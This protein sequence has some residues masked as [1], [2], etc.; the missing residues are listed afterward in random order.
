MFGQ[1]CPTLISGIL[2]EMRACMSVCCMC[3][4]HWLFYALGYFIPV[5]TR[6]VSSSVSNFLL[7]IWGA[8]CRLEQH[9]KMIIQENG[10]CWQR[11]CGWV[12]PCSVAVMKCTHCIAS[13]VGGKPFESSLATNAL[14][15]C[16]HPCR[17][18]ECRVMKQLCTW[19]LIIMS[20]TNF[21]MS[22]GGDGCFGK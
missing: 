22:D 10:C 15:V 4:E 19:L 16:Q 2:A 7:A 21:M 13:K 5:G 6:L 17:K 9:I 12:A 1:Y 8:F 11:C 20:K 14:I 3:D 18:T